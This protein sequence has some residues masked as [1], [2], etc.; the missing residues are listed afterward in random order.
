MFETI[1]GGLSALGD[2]AHVFAL[3]ATIAS[4]RLASLWAVECAQGTYGRCERCH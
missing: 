4:Y 3:V 1:V 2:A